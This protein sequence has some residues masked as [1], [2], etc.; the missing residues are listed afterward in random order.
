MTIDTGSCVMYTEAFLWGR[1]EMT[2]IEKLGFLKPAYHKII[3]QRNLL[4]EIG[5]VHKVR[6]SLRGRSIMEFVIV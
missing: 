3:I 4:L 2:F 5:L 6:H 1:L